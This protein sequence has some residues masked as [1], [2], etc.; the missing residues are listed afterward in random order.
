MKRTPLARK[1]P[2][3]AKTGLKNK[4]MVQSASSRIKTSGNGK[5]KPLA[6]RS[7]SELAKLKDK[8]WELCKNITRARYGGTC[9]TCDKQGLEGS[10]QQTGHYL[11]DSTCSTELRYDLNNLRIQCYRC[12]INLSGNWI[13]YER[14]LIRDHG[15]EYVAELKRRNYATKGLMYREDWYKRKIEEYKALL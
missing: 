12:N 14:R 9:Y 15:E 1:T 8:L 2:L 7:K 10:N 4:G 6:R 3:K 13:E 5:N 11:T